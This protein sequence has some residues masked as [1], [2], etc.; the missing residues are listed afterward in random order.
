M[1]P[2]P[3]HLE[4]MRHFSLHEEGLWYGTEELPPSHKECMFHVIERKAID[5]M[6]KDM[7]SMAKALED[8]TA[9]DDEG[10][11]FEDQRAQDIRWA[12]NEL[13]NYY[14]KYGVKK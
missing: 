7:E 3:K 8:I 10:H 12:D 4:E 13:K 11:S 14:E 1:T 2:L 5:I 9:K 6:L